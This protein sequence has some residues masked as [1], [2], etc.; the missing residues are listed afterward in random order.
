[1]RYLGVLGLALVSTHNA[2]NISCAIYAPLLR[3]FCHISHLNP[4]KMA[5]RRL[6]GGDAA[7]DVD[8][9]QQA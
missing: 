9:C 4:G 1:M 7:A 6:P 8:K 2:H 5:W 3:T